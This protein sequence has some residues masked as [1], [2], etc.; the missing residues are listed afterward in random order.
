MKC[1]SCKGSG[2]DG[3]D[4]LY[5]KENPLNCIYCGGAG[6]QTF[7]TW[8]YWTRTYLWRKYVFFPFYDLKKKL[9]ARIKTTR[10]RNF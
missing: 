3:L 4:A 5:H 6:Q 10:T 1:W 8:F 2:K 9:Y 7:R